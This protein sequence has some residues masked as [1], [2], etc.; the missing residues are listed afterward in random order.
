M[1]QHQDF[2]VSYSFEAVEG[3]PSSNALPS[4]LQYLP[5]WQVS[6]KQVSICLMVSGNKTVRGDVVRKNIT[7]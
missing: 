6:A 5:S 3:L 2:P 7:F 1:P 4:A